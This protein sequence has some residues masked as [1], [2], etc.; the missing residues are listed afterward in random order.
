MPSIALDHSEPRKA[1][2]GRRQTLFNPVFDFMCLGGG[3]LL[4]LPLLALVRPADFSAASLTSLG[5][6]TA[7][8]INH[9]HF[10]HSYQIFYR[11]F[12]RKAFGRNADA[13]LRARYV[14]AGIVVPV[15]LALY[16]AVTIANGDVAALGYA[17]NF[18]LFVVG[19]HYVKQG[20]G[21]IIVDSVLKRQFFTE[22]EKKY[23]LV[24]S[25]A[26]WISYWLFANWAVAET[27]LFG[28]KYYMF[29]VP[30]AVLHASAAVTA[31]TSAAT[32]AMLVRKWRANG[33][34]LPFN[35]LAAYAAALYPWL[36][37]RVDPYFLFF[38]PTFHSLQYLVVV[39]RYQLNIAEDKARSDAESAK[40]DDRSGL[41]RPQ[42]RFAGFV[43][44]GTALGFA[45]FWLVPSI[46]DSFLRYDTSVF[47]TTLFFA[48][49]WIFIN[50]HHYFLDNVM[51]R[52]AN[53]ETSKYLFQAS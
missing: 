53:P 39:W 47:G 8:V 26:C 12:A 20:Y 36:F 3:S 13:D 27:E 11:G 4:C 42:I 25:Y 23:L 14:V 5:F 34:R 48:V 31:L 17:G 32:V 45:G 40:A 41:S 52:R 38:A 7:L 37:L 35:G 51:W 1:N 49:V 46:L 24:N 28:L 19:W 30:E 21:M 16:F 10:A 6:L 33:R 44:A 9:P 18:M 15:L 22:G 50:V 43:L 2:P 29:A